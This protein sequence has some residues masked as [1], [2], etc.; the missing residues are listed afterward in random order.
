[1][2]SWGWYLTLVDSE[3]AIWRRFVTPGHL[4]VGTL[5]AIV[6]GVM[7]WSGQQPYHF[8]WQGQAHGPELA[9][10]AVGD[11]GLAVG[12]RIPYTYYPQRGW[13][14]ILELEAVLADSSPQVAAIGDAIAHCVAGE[15]ACPPE[16]CDGIWGYGDL[17][18][19]MGDPEDPD[20][21]ALMDWVGWDFNPDRFD[22]AAAN[23]RLTQLA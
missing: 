19:R 16:D 23:E 9:T 2:T 4:S 17:L 1:M 11:W 12:D 22:L 5:H 10:T 8:Q 20:Y 6:Q 15:M 18:D 3:P 7:G 13:L 14:H 21:E